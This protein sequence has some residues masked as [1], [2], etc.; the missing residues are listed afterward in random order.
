[1]LAA[2]VVRPRMPIEYKGVLICLA[3]VFF[4]RIYS[5]QFNLWFYPFLIL[6]SSATTG[7]TSAASRPP[8]WFSDL[9]NV[10]VYPISFAGAVAEMGGFF[11]WA[12]RE[13]GRWTVVFSAAIA[14]RTVVVAL[15][16]V[17]ILQARGGQGGQ[18]ARERQNQR[19]PRNGEWMSKEDLIELQGVVTEVPGRRQLQGQVRREPRG[20]RPPQRQDA[21]VPHP[22]DRGRPR[23][24]RR[25][26]LRP[27]ARPHHVPGEVDL[28]A[29]ARPFTRIIP[30]RDRGWTRC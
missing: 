26:A 30:A 22:R 25:L 14:L 18:R 20:P 2:V 21:P 16:A 10:L 1:M 15:L 19:S 29:G 5:T 13:G 9:L 6:G 11:P 4:N 28:P 23:H 7:G 8:S 3:A 12:A 24:R 17:L 27:Q